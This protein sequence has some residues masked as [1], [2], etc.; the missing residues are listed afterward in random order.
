MKGAAPCRR[1]GAVGGVLLSATTGST[2]S[3]SAGYG[4]NCGRPGCG[5]GGT[6]HCRGQGGAGTRGFSRRSSGM[7][8][9]S[10]RAF[11]G[12]AFPGRRATRTLRCCWR[13]M[14]CGGGPR[15][16]PRMTRGSSRSGLDECDI[17]RYNLGVGRTLGSVHRVDL[18]GDRRDEAAGQLVAAVALKL[19]IPQGRERRARPARGPGRL[20]EARLEVGADRRRG[21]GRRRPAARPGPTGQYW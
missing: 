5:C 6:R 20:A 18:F 21:P 19:G 4:G 7:G 10:S 17:P 12:R 14:S 9:C 16:S 3:G 8:S 2:R 15:S 1:R 11:P 13:S